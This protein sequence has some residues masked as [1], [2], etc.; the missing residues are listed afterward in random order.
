MA[1][2]Y[3]VKELLEKYGVDAVDI[4]F[5]VDY[6]LKIHVGEFVEETPGHVPPEEFRA[7]NE[8]KRALAYDIATLLF[9]EEAA[10]AFVPSPHT[11]EYELPKL[12]SRLPP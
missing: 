4:S 9:G 8:R 2:V 6:G 1:I 10:P 12:P 7:M 3:D 5:D 11:E